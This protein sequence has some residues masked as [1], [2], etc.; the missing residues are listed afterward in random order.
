MDTK[1]ETLDPTD[2]HE[3]GTTRHANGKRYDA[4]SFYST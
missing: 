2:W 4:V 1:E 3:H